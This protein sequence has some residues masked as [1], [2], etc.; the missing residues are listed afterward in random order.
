VERQLVSQV[1]SRSLTYDCMVVWISHNKSD[2]NENCNKTLIIREIFWEYKVWPED[3][4]QC[5]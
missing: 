3:W 1:I 5:I 2:E 4:K